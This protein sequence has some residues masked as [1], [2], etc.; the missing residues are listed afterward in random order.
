MHL[1]T[2][3]L[4]S[5]GGG[6]FCI[7]YLKTFIMDAMLDKN[8]QPL[9]AEHSLDQSSLL[10]KNIFLAFFLGALLSIHPD[11]WQCWATQHGVRGYRSDHV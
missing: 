2:V 1:L 3:P 11:P 9:A 7:G 10:A 8:T 6:E 4:N 5:R